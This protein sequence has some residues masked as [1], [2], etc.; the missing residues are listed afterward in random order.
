MNSDHVTKSRLIG[1][2]T[3]ALFAGCVWYGVWSILPPAV[4]R[5]PVADSEFSSQ[6][7]MR[8]LEEIAVQPHPMGSEANA[9]VRDYL[10]AELRKLRYEV[11]VQQATHQFSNS[12]SPKG[13]EVPLSNIIGRL[14]GRKPGPAVALACHYD[15]APLAPG[16]GDDGAA[17]AAIIETARAVQAGLPL[18]NDL[19][20]LITDGEE[21]GLLG[22]REFVN[23]HPLAKRIGVVF[24]FDGR[25]RRGPAILME[26]SVGNGRLIRELARATPFR[27]GSTIAYEVYTRMPNSTDMA[28]FREAQLPG[29]NFCI[30]NGL[31]FYHQP[32]DNVQNAD[33]PTVQQIGDNA[34]ALSRHFG[35]MEIANLSDED[36]IFFNPCGTFLAHYPAYLNRPLMITV[37]VAA[38]VGI[39]F[40]IKRERISIRSFFGGLGV[41]AVIVCCGVAPVLAVS[42]WM[43][44]WP[45]H[46]AAL[47][48]GD[49]P[50]GNLFLGG[51]AALTI[52]G[53]TASNALFRR[54][55]SLASVGIS[56]SVIWL[57]STGTV[58]VVFPV[59]CYQFAWPLAWGCWGIVAA[60]I[61]KDGV[62]GSRH[63]RTISIGLQWLAMAA[64]VVQF[65]PIYFLLGL[66]VGT[67]NAWMT[68]VPLAAFGLL[69]VPCWELISQTHRW[70]LPVVCVLVAVVSLGLA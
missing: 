37:L 19:I 48:N 34:L 18:E 4:R 44:H 26:T 38:A 58:C 17:V 36:R 10:V 27:L 30:H 60:V 63:R 12:A 54:Q 49:L 39:I 33:E 2:A 68:A 25:G 62:D 56:G 28:V 3:L 41:S 8:H 13:H 24:N 15:S 52:A 16:A 66:T 35:N 6:R 70:L 53:I 29:L 7:A 23:Q 40:L 5:G 31:A 14:P 67:A 21:A 32:A 59:A 57:G 55:L 47:V 1:W 45:K 61:G 11:E 51:F 69:L 65:A 46:Q 43:L 64:I 50:N 22:A 9:K 42:A 20:I